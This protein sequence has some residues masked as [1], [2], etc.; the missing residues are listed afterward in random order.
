MTAVRHTGI[1]VG[2]IERAL[3][4]YCGL[5][6]FSV[7]RRML[8]KGPFV[9]AILGVADAEVETVKLSGE[10][11]GQIE[12]LAFAKPDTTLGVAP[13]LFRQGPTHVA[14]KVRDIDAL[15]LRMRDKGIEFTT[16]PRVSPDGG[17]KVTFCRDP[18]GTFLELVEVLQK[19]AS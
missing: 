10:G 5:L 7:V 1:V 14:L 19:A 6:D 16:P 18:D 12:L 2:D 4:F 9:S 11:T 8:E 3:E 15:Y 17:A 13:S